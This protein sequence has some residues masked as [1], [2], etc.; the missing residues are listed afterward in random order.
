MNIY[1]VYPRS[2]IESHPASK[3]SKL[4]ILL[5][6]N[7][8]THKKKRKKRVNLSYR[9]I[10]KQETHNFEAE[11]TGLPPSPKMEGIQMYSLVVVLHSLPISSS[12]CFFTLSF[13]NVWHVVGVEYINDSIAVIYILMD[14]SVCVIISYITHH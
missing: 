2:W 1:T 13:I 8:N 9:S 10:S 14:L 11:V 12:L 5:H 6:C 3:L 4:K 7:P